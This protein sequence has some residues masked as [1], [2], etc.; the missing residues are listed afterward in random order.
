[1]RQLRLVYRD[2][3]PDL[4]ILE[5]AELSAARLTSEIDLLRGF[6][7]RSPLFVI[8]NGVLSGDRLTIITDVADFATAEATPNEIVARLSRVLG[9]A[10]QK[11]RR[12]A[13][14]SA[15]P[16]SRTINGVRID[17]RTKEATYG[18]STVRFSTAELRMLE[19]LLER[20]GQTLSTGA[21]LRAVWGDDRQRSESL[22][23]VYIWAVRGK[24]SRFGL[25]FGIETMIGSGYRLTI[26]ATNQK[27]RKSGGPRHGPARRSA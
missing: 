22:V 16:P 5:V 15:L 17:W 2:R 12:S 3:E 6:G 24:L 13:Q 20:R 25:K 8:S 4:V 11:P 23:P 26:G 19:A 1:M 18:D 14:T 21:L 10:R 7:I 9:Q 27:K